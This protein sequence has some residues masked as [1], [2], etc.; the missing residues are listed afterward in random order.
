MIK[1]QI[2]NCITA[3]RILLSIPI[4]SSLLEHDYFSALCYLIVAGFS[5][6]LDGFLARRFNWQTRLGTIL[7][8]LADKLLVVSSFGLLAW[9]QVIPSWLFWVILVKDLSV[10]MGAIL[11]HYF[12][13]SYE[14]SASL[15]SKTNT[16]L[17]LSFLILILIQ[18]Q[19]NG[20]PTWP[21]RFVMY[22]ILFTTLACMVHYMLVWGIKAYKQT[23]GSV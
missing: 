5:D 20:F 3:L 14:F 7:D 15:L 8:P 13:G 18:L 12:I 16:F 6:G 11:Y 9:T 17:Q 19:V 4:A 10:A 23:H 1:R 2:P 21:V 22:T